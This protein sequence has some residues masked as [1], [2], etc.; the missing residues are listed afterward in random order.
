MIGVNT[1]KMTGPPI[2]FGGLKTSR[3]GREGARQGLDE[4]T[5]IKYVCLA[6]IDEPPP[7]TVR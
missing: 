5:E 7:L 2:P 6:G 1:A 3:L 4:Y